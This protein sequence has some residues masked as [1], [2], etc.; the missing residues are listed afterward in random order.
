MKYSEKLKASKELLTAIQGLK[1]EESIYVTY[2]KGFKGVPNVYSIK[3][4]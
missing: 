3:A 1:D 4:Y 2:G